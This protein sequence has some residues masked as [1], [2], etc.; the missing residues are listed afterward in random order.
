LAQKVYEGGLEAKT[1]QQLIH[2]IKSKI[3]EFDSFFVESLM[4]G[5]KA[6][7]TSIGDNGVYSFFK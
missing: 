4:Q 5:V 2:R 6:K 3:K 1:E 7:V